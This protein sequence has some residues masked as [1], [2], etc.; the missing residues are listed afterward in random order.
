LFAV[1]AILGVL[2][3]LNLLLTYGVIRRLREHT[4]VLAQ[5]RIG[6]PDLLVVAG[7]PI[8]TF[9]ATTTEGHAFAETDLEPGTLVGFFSTGCGACVE[10]LPRFVQVAAAHPGGRDRVLAVVIGPETESADQV[11]ALS[12]NA[13]VV[14]ARHGHAIESAFEVMAFPAFALLGADG[15]VT[16]SGDLEAVT[17]AAVEAIA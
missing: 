10:T 2:C 3:L 5:Q 11:A 12:P 1:V 17:G 8:G 4:E 14:V 15:V 16:A 13:R 7:S 9:A 6:S